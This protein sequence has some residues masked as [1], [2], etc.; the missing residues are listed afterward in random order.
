MQVQELG[1]MM[2]ALEPVPGLDPD[3]F[4]SVLR[5]GGGET[6]ARDCD[7]RHV[8]IVQLAKRSRSLSAKLEREKAR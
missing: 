1:T 7:Y 2:E 8:K 6:E 4:L 5:G 3:A